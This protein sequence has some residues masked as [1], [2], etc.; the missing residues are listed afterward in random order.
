VT[1]AAIGVRGLTKRYK[2]GALANDDIDLR[3]ERGT[4][5]LTYTT[6]NVLA[7]VSGIL[8]V[9]LSV[10]FS[11]SRLPDWLQWPA[12]FSPYTH[13]AEALKD[14]LSGSVPLGEV[15]I[16]A[17]LSAVMVSLGIAGMRWR[18]L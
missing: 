9:M 16:L 6:G 2:N 10:Y 3:V 7:E 17:A 12:R 15:A 4:W 18:D 13:A 1:R 8:V 11:V 14:S 5:S